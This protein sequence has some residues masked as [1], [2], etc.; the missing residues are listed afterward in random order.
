M[1]GIIRRYLWEKWIKVKLINE[2]KLK[3]KVSSIITVL[4]Q[5]S[6][7]KWHRSEKGAW[8]RRLIP[9]IEPW[10]SRKHD[11]TTFHLS[12]T[13]SDHGY[14]SKYLH[15]IAKNEDKRCW[16]CDEDDSPEHMLEPEN[17]IS[18][19]LK[20]AESWDI[21]VAYISEVLLSKEDERRL[22]RAY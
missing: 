13:L 8:T 18:V 7:D 17:V 5:K 11:E 22:L 21:V 15:F 19:M 1:D 2:G 10:L 6:Q 20:S 14:F 12:Q 4:L 3:F 16:Y 9:Q